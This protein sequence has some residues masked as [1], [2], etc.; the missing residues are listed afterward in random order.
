MLHIGNIN[1][2]QPTL[3]L[4]ENGEYVESYN[5]D[6]DDDDLEDEIIFPSPLDNADVYGIFQAFIK[7]AFS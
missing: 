2:E 1:L 3:K 5:D 6:I 4:D 7:C